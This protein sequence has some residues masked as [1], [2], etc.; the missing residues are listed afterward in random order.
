MVLHINHFTFKMEKGDTN[1]DVLPSGL[2]KGRD[3]IT[4][5]SNSLHSECDIAFTL[6]GVYLILVQQASSDATALLIFC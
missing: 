5:R 3:S 1:V 4:K 2:F 6:P